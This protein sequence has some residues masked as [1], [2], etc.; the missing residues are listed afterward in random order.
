M[1][2]IEEYQINFADNICASY[3]ALWPSFKW[4]K[5]VRS[6]WRRR[7]DNATWSCCGEQL[8]LLATTRTNTYNSTCGLCC[9]CHIH[10]YFTLT[11]FLMHRKINRG[12]LLPGTGHRK[13][14]LS[15]ETR[16]RQGAARERRPGVAHTCRRCCP[17]G[18]RWGHGTNAP[19]VQRWSL[20]REVVLSVFTGLS[21]GGCLCRH[22][23]Y[24]CFIWLIQWL[25][26]SACTLYVYML[27][28]NGAKVANGG[29]L[30]FLFLNAK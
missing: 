10:F 15:P 12:H 1:L 29:F 23:K 16:G 11:V 4:R 17:G 22:F 14:G 6:E 30:S 18:F 19:A 2:T 3:P 28:A 9:F 24:F 25:V 20:M 5:W 13:R 27:Q 21:H 26:A 8:S 7:R